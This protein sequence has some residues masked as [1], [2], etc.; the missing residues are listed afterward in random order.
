MQVCKYVSAH[1]AYMH[2]CVFMRRCVCVTACVYVCMQIWLYVGWCVE[3]RYA[4]AY[5]YS[6]DCNACVYMWMHLNA[7]CVCM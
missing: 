4:C 3:R 1:C 7:M 2:T 5:V 6:C